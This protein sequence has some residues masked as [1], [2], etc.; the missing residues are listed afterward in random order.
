MERKD[1]TNAVIFLLIALPAILAIL[2][3]AYLITRLGRDIPGIVAA[4]LSAFATVAAL[5]YV[6]TEYRKKSAPFY[7]AFLLLFAAAEV[8]VVV[9]HAL[10]AE[11]RLIP[12][13][14]FSIAATLLVT[15]TFA[16]DI[17]KSCSFVFCFAI[18]AA[19][20]A[21]LLFGILEPI[22]GG[23]V[24]LSIILAVSGIVL[25]LLLAIMIFAKYVDKAI[26][27]SK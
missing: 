16:K 9:R 8:A 13:V 7:R 14:L 20:V 21:E 22:E 4:S 15:L 12:V 5:T 11:P 17:G 3:D 2:A 26:R 1:S 24:I 27:H 6:F 19:N 25:S 10:E 23:D 18:F